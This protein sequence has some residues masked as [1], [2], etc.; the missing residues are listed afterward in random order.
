MS[1]VLRWRGEMEKAL[2]V[3]ERVWLEGGNKE[4]VAGGDGI[5]VAD[6]QI[7]CELEQPKLA[8]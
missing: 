7:A 1:Y 6:L 2:D 5:T 8:G 4:F 3:V